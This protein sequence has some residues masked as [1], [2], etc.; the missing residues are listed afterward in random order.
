MIS[1][2]TMG[3]HYGFL[4]WVLPVASWIFI[5]GFAQVL[6]LEVCAEGGVLLYGTSFQNVWHPQRCHIHLDQ[7]CCGRQ[8]TKLQSFHEICLPVKQ[9]SSEFGASTASIPG[10]FQQMIITLIPFESCWNIDLERPIDWGCPIFFQP[11]TSHKFQ[12]RLCAKQPQLWV[13]EHPV[14]LLDAGS[15]KT[16]PRRF[17]KCFDEFQI[18]CRFPDSRL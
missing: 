17:F 11:K 8:Q 3:F 4:R 7:G 9:V 1:W 18:L 13:A 10:R 15:Y 6:P 12:P 2:P 16:R 5:V 14:M